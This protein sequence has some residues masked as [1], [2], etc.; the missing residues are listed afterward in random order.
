MADIIYGK[1]EIAAEQYNGRIKAE[2]LSSFVCE[3]FYSMF[4]ESAN[5]RGKLSL[6][7]SGPSQ[8][9]AKSRTAWKKVGARKFTIPVRSPDLNPIENVFNIVKRKWH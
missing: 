2:K 7:N 8:N 3:H 6:Q 4:K 9:S 1:G 5:P